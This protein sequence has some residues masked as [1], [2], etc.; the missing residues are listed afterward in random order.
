M[1]GGIDYFD[2]ENDGQINMATALRQPGSAIKPITYFAAFMKDVTPSTVIYDVPKEY[3]TNSG[4]G[5]IPNNYDGK[6]HGL[7]LPREALA[8]S[9]NLPAVEMLNRIGI[10]E[11]M[12]TS[13]KL[14]ITSFKRID[15]YDL[16]LTLGGGEISLLQLTNAYASIEEGGDYSDTVLIKEVKDNKGKL[17][18]K[19][20][21]IIKQNQFGEYSKQAAYL[22]T[23]ILSDP[24]ARIPGFNEN[25]PLVLPFDAAAK[26]GTT[27]DWHDNW[28]IGFT[29]DHSLGV[30][31]GNNNN[32]AM[33]DITGITGAAP[34]WHDFFIEVYKYYGSE[35]PQFTRPQG[36]TEVEIC[37]KSG[38]LPDGICPE[39][40]KEIFIEGTEPK[41]RS[42]INILMN[43]DIRN[44]L[45]A[46]QNCPTQYISSKIFT[47]VS[48]RNL[49]MGSP[50][51]KRFHTDAIF[52]VM[53]FKQ[54]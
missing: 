18:Y 43:I 32:N 5:F 11:F 47:N 40:Y 20:N 6:Y 2:E 25:N 30:W 53:S 19:N 13:T 3:K 35:P 4:E 49:F 29:S 39:T 51:H 1:V 37:K 16:A 9:Y 31:I 36:I 38:L 24:I 14:G 44:G 21:G 10:E 52:S 15:E 12:N 28:T 46:G 50:K 45:P 41:E 34:I 42:N 54:Y 8:S 7:V 23:D 17:I 22:V 27:T 26:T 48:T 33:K